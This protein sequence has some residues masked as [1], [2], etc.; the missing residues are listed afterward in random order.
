MAKQY[1]NDLYL[2]IIG[3]IYL[4]IIG[5]RNIIAISN[6]LNTIKEKHIELNI[7]KE[8]HIELNIIKPNILGHNRKHYE[9]KSNDLYYKKHI[10]LAHQFDTNIYNKDTEMLSSNNFICLYFYT[11]EINYEYINIYKI[12]T[13]NI[14]IS[15]KIYN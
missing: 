6:D 7:I 11:P 1:T 13:G 3:D 9:T 2:D 12:E 5:D 10:V 15:R 14:R 4:D 8:K